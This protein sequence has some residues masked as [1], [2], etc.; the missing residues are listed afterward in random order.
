M[1]LVILR[2]LHMLAE[3]AR[4]TGHPERQ[5][6]ILRQA[7]LVVGECERVGLLPADLELIR[8]AAA[9]VEAAAE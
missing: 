7:A 5:P 2:S 6:P 9:R 1:V 4:D 8:G 3:T